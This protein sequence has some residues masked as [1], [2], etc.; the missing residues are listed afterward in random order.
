MPI[1]NP[2]TFAPADN[3]LLGLLAASSGSSLVGF[4]QS[5]T[6]AVATDLQTKARELPATP[7]D[8]AVPSNGADAT[9]DLNLLLANDN[10]LVTPNTYT[11]TNGGVNFR[12]KVEGSHGSL[13]QSTGVGTDF[14]VSGPSAVLRDVSLTGTGTQ[15][16]SASGANIADVLLD[17][18]IVTNTGT[19]AALQ[20]NASGASNWKIANSTLTAEGYALLL[21]DNITGGNAYAIVGNKLTSNLADALEI[22]SPNAVLKDIAAVANILKAGTAGVSV[23]AGFPIGIAA[24]QNGAFIG[25]AISQSRQEAIHVEDG[26]K[27]LAF[28]GNVARDV[29]GNGIHS[30]PDPSGEAR[31]SVFI[32]NNLEADSTVAGK[33]GINN[34]TSAT[35]AVVPVTSITRVGQKATVTT[36]TPH[37]MYTWQTCT[38]AGAAQAEY[39]V[40][41]TVIVTGPSTFEYYLSGAPATP[42]TGVITIT[43][44]TVFTPGQVFI[45]NRLK[46]FDLGA[47]SKIGFT[48]LDGNVFEEATTA[49]IAT[50]SAFLIGENLLSQQVGVPAALITFDGAGGIYGKVYSDKTPTAVLARTSAGIP[51]AMRGFCFPVTPYVHGGGTSDSV[52]LVAL[53]DFACGRVIARVRRTISSV[54]WKYVSA[55]I[56]WDGTTLLVSNTFLRNNGNVGSS[57]TFTV[58]GGNLCIT[59]FIATPV[60]FDVCSID[61]SGEWVKA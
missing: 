56:F 29:H 31:G 59:V 57:V 53:P 58:V 9:A 17:H 28:I 19:G 12:N 16:L 43:T 49:G 37:K 8:W 3:T 22:N 20:V 33:T 27:T 6:G 32:G 10:V 13:L 47:D 40:L 7:V 21:N 42:A 52:P 38:I 45:G 46:D 25:N 23:S 35:G 24:A 11:S 34:L 51:G 36:T 50:S 41:V 5:G 60:V 48:I 55:D 26:V 18:V 44:G 30:L 1:V 4:I 54:D 14:T 39:N 15:T 2:S 61:F